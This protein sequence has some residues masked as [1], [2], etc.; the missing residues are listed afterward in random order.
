MKQIVKAGAGVLLAG[1]SCSALADVTQAKAFVDV[2]N[3]FFSA[4][5]ALK[6]SPFVDDGE[7]IFRLLLLILIAWSG[8]WGMLSEGGINATIGRLVKTILMAGIALFFLQTSTQERLIQGFDYLA[9]KAVKASGATF[10]VSNPASGIL[11]VARQGL[12]TVNVLWVG[13]EEG[14]APTGEESSKDGEGKAPAWFKTLV[15]EKWAGVIVGLLVSNL[16]K[17]VCTLLVLLTYALF[18]FVMA[19]AQV[20]VNIGILLAPIF[21]P[22]LLWEGTAFLFH[23]WLKFII[24][25]GMQ[26]VVAATVF[27]MTCNLLKGVEKLSQVAASNPVYDGAAYTAA[28]ML[29]ALAA[30]CMLQVPSIASGLVS[31]LPSVSLGSL[32]GIQPKSG[33]KGKDDKSK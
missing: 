4:A 24:V 28:V 19:M 31:G 26:K 27:G 32:R 12:T 14:T 17:L 23:S 8:I 15:S 33:G 2:I 20:L 7:L 29:C 25:A 9:V 5:S 6:N 10:D 13:S 30:F 21:I 22:W 1:V 3:G 16:M 11:E 18:I